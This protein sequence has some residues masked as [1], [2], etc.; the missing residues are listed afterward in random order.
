MDFVAAVRGLFGDGFFLC[1]CRRFNLCE[2]SATGALLSGLAAALKS[3][4]W[5]LPD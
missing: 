4:A 5:K 3:L 1:G 2:A